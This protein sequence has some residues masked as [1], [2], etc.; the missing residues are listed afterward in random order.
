MADD[1]V[2]LD[3][4]AACYVE[5]GEPAE[6]ARCYHDAGSYRRAADLY[7]QVGLYREAADAY[8]RAR[9]HDFAIWHLAHYV[10]DVAGARA[11]ES[12]GQPPGDP[13]QLRWRLAVARCDIADHRSDSGPLGVLADA[14]RYL[15]RPLAHHDPYVESWAAA[16]ATAMRREDQVALLYAAGVRG[17]Y[18]GAAERWAAWSRDTLHCELILPVAEPGPAKTPAY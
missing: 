2:L 6:A 4:A 3:R 10:G 11:L 17:H 8:A 15:E 5:A 7:S 16:I 12:T 1:P 13:R 9:M 14:C 18:D